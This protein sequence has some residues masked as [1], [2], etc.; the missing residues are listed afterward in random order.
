M[1]KYY[2]VNLKDRE[3]NIIYPN[4]HN[5][6][7]FDKDG[8]VTISKGDIKASNGKV[9]YVHA[10][11][12]ESNFSF[13][14]SYESFLGSVI[15]SNN[16]WFSLINVKHRNNIDDGINYGL[17]IRNQFGTDKPIQYRS[18]SNAKWGSW[19]T[20]MNL[21]QAQTISGAKTFTNHIYLNG[22]TDATSTSTSKIIFGNNTT[23]YIVLRANSYKTLMISEDLT[24]GTNAIEYNSVSPCFKPV[25]DNTVYL[26]LENQRWKNIF[27]N[28]GN[29]NGNITFT[30]S[31]TNHRGILGTFGGNDQW[32]I[33]GKGTG[34]DSGYMLIATGDNGNEPIYVRQYNGVPPSETVARTLTLL[35]ESGNSSFPGKISVTST[36][37]TIGGNRIILSKTGQDGYWGLVTPS[38]SDSAW[39]R[40]TSLGILPYKSGGASS[41]GTSSWPFT[42]VYANTFYGNLQ[43]GASSAYFPRNGWQAIIKGQKWSRIMSL[44]ANNVTIGCNGILS[45]GGTRSNVVFNYLFAINSCHPAGRGNITLISSSQYTN[46]GIRLLTDTSGNAIV[47]VYDSA[48][49]IASGTNQSLVCRWWPIMNCTCT[50]VTSFTDDTTLP[51]GYGLAVSYTAISG[52][53]SL[54]ADTSLHEARMGAISTWNSGYTGYRNGTVMFCW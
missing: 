11:T 27:A 21:E 30:D 37:S 19:Y 52:G 16:T 13:D 28:E 5:N 26:G 22:I 18:Q 8:N 20:V 3:N 36:E 44:R 25:T 6:W 34:N 43:G 1:P 53:K 14:N 29:F 48:V 23:P 40:T 31:S 46:I 41:L 4:I 10:G 32:Y 54:C 17:Q 15:N 12:I 50:E 35:D 49:N 7:I 39:I 51:N 33:G 47:D 9:K 38:N 45:I 42:A 2:R 24:D